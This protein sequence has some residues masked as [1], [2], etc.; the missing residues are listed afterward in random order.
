MN[1][2]LYRQ[3]RSY[4]ISNISVHD[5]Q[6]DAQV[7]ISTA[8][9]TWATH[10]AWEMAFDGWKRQR[11]QILDEAGGAMKT[12]RWSDFK[13][14]L[15]KEHVVDSDWPAV[16]DDGGQAVLGTGADSGAEWDYA[17]MTFN[18]AGTR[19]DDY[20]VGLMGTHQFSS[21]TNET[22]PHDILYDGY[23]S[24]LEGLQEIRQ[25]PVDATMDASVTNAVFAGFNL[26]SPAAVMDNIIEIQDENNEAPY[27]MEFVGSNSNPTDDTGAFPVRECHISSSYA[28]M[29]MLGPI[30][31]IPCGLLQVRTTASS[32]NTIGL[33]IELTP[34]NYKGVHAPPMGN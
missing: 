32:N 24:C 31:E 34:G 9:N 26:V 17:D 23:I 27:S 5:S 8:P 18:K 30:P 2:R 25:Q 1:R 11:A 4:S 6:G 21:I 16:V 10:A 28:P 3:G 7:L 29:A 20:A 13:V 12:P 22:T 15:N 33:L 19:Y 14:Y